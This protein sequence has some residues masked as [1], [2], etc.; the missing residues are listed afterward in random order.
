MP[1]KNPTG[2]WEHRG[3]YSVLLT[4]NASTDHLP[5]EASLMGRTVRV[6]NGRIRQ[7]MG[8]IQFYADGKP[9]YWGYKFIKEIRD[10]AGK[11]IWQNWDYR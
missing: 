9:L 2:Y 11:L 3:S 4:D 6:E 8:G 10:G 1:H 5:S 7:V